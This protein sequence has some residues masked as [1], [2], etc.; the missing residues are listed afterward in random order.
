LIKVTAEFAENTETFLESF[1]LA[2][3]CSFLQWAQLRVCWKTV[4]SPLRR[5]VCWTLRFAVSFP[6]GSIITNHPVL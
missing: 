3:L 2:A 1:A 6:M 5:K 4:V